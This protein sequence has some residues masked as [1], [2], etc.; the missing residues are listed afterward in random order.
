MSPVWPFAKDSPALEQIH[1]T[2]KL[3]EKRG[4]DRTQSL[5]GLYLVFTGFF[6]QFTGAFLLLL[7]TL[8]ADS[9]AQGH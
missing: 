2:A 3:G 9:G 7:A 4:E 6:L 5:I 1:N 8:L